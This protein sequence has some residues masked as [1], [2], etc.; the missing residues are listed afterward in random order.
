M[1]RVLP[2]VVITI[3]VCLIIVL[4]NKRPHTSSSPQNLEFQTLNIVV[5]PE[6]ADFGSNEEEWVRKETRR[7]SAPGRIFHGNEGVVEGVAS[8]KAQGNGPN[9]WR[10]LAKVKEAGAAQDLDAFNRM[11]DEAGNAEFRREVVEQPGN[12]ALF[13]QQIAAFQE[14]SVLVAL[15]VDGMLV[16]VVKDAGGAV[17]ALPMTAKDG[18]YVLCHPTSLPKDNL[19]LVQRLELHLAEKPAETLLAK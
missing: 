9:M 19:K 17:R 2:V 18:E 13:K 12:A 1:K 10:T 14:M 16:P 6:Q 8:E 4:K 7:I 3:L 5:P 15:D 11:L